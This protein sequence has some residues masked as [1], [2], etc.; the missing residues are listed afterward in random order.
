MIAKRYAV[1]LFT[2]CLIL[3]CG[4]SDPVEMPAPPAE[5]ELTSDLF[6]VDAAGKA[7]VPDD[8]V[9]RQILAVA[10]SG[11][12]A[13]SLPMVTVDYPFNGTVYPP[14][15]VPPT[16]RW[17]DEAAAAHRWVVDV[18]FGEGSA[19]LYLLV[20]GGPP[21]A[22]EIDHRALGEAN[23]LY[24]PTEY[25]ASAETWRPSEQAWATIRRNSL[26]RKTR[27]T[28][29]GSGEQAPD[30]ALSRGSFTLT[31]SEDPV[32]APIFYRDVPLMPSATTEG[33]IQPLDPGAV[34]LLSLIHI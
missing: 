7:E 16:V 18:E 29:Y 15:M 23:E 10:A 27:V 3:G 5:P 20:P 31:T 14:D 34:P 28:F 21:A 2:A 1:L 19:H 25:Q 30:K 9:R 4:G 32:G 26:G 17:H 12:S 13:G 22:G 6:L 24:Q 11:R 33:V 8:E